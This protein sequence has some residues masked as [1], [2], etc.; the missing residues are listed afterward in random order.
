VSLPIRARLTLWHVAALALVI[1]ALGAFVAVR[2]RADLTSDFDRS[3]HSAGTQIRAGYERGGAD[4]S[5][6]GRSDV[7]RV[8]PADSGMQLVTPTGRIAAAVGRDL[9]RSSLLG[10]ARL[11][12]VLAGEDTT[13]TTHGPSDSEPFRVFGTSVRRGGERQALVVASSLEGVDSAVHRVVVLMLIAGPLALLAVAAGGWWLTRAALRPVER[14]TRQAERIE[15]DRLDD[16]V[17]VPPGSDEI[18]HLALTLNRML[19]RLSRGVEDKRRLVADASHELRT[20]LAAMQAELDVALAYDDLEP[21]ARAVLASAREEVDRMGRT[22]D[23]LLTL[24][25]ADDG[26]LELVRQP[27]ALRDVAD[28]VAAELGPA[29]LE[30][31]VRLLAAGDGALVD[32]DPARLRQVVANLV[33]NAVKYSPDGGEVRAEAWR[34]NGEVGLTVSDGGAGIPQSELGHVFDRFYRVDSS[35][36][37]ATG[38]SGLGLAICREIVAAH[39]GRIWAE[40]EEGRGSRFTLA[41]PASS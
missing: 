15:V 14:L 34:A 22:V 25:R 24:A 40:S 21:R 38:G 32:G 35:R 17:S 4:A 36:V 29:A 12:R 39:G 26:R 37:R 30:R 20:P 7:I 5:A 28:S 23:D 11:R 33:D 41:L 9:P 3:L 2:L 18:A 27:V 6:A 13:I 8:L 1:A 16:R 10:P 19:D 31:G